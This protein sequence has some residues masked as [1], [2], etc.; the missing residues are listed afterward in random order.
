LNSTLLKALFRRGF[1]K[2]FTAL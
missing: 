1:Q 2:S